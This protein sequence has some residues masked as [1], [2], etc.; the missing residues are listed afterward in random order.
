[1]TVEAPAKVVIRRAADSQTTGNCEAINPGRRRNRRPAGAVGKEH[2][3][4]IAA[5]KVG[6]GG[7]DAVAVNA[8]VAV[9]VT[10]EHR[11]I[12]RPI[13][14]GTARLCAHKA[15]IE[16]DATSKLKSTVD[17]IITLP[18]AF[19]GVV[20][21]GGHP[22]FTG[23]DNGERVLEIGEGVIPVAAILVAS[24][25]GLHVKHTCRWTSDCGQ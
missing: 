15:A 23:L 7:D 9:N 1:M 16:C 21:T 12:G 2:V 25:T 20:D 6:R 13:A 24:A 5:D 14:V 10:R 3:I 11:D 4:G 18:C 19:I 8:I 17:V 22:D